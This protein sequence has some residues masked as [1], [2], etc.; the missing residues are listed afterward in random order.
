MVRKRFENVKSSFG[1]RENTW[2]PS[3]NYGFRVRGE[4]IGD[5]IRSGRDIP[6]YRCK[7]RCAE[8]KSGVGG[9]GGSMDIG[10][11]VLF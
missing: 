2:Q 9:G 1:W 3:G 11:P 4:G 7:Y 10:N 6:N 8:R 5:E